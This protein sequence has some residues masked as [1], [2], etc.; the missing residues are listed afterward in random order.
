MSRLISVEARSV[1]ELFTGEQGFRL[2]WFQ[3]AYAWRT[4]QV[5]R[6]IGDLVE[7][8]E[9]KDDA[10]FLLGTL[11][12]AEAA[13]RDRLAIVDGHQRIMTL[14]IIAAVLRDL[15]APG[16]VRSRLDALVG[17]GHGGYRFEPQSYI[18]EFLERYVQ[19]DGGTAL[20]VDE[21]EA[22][23]SD[24]ERCV[25]EV[26]E[27][28]LSRLQAGNS[29][30]ILRADIALLLL[31][32][33][34]VIV[35]IY[36]SEDYAWRMLDVEE[37]TRLTF[38]PGAQ[39]KATILGVMPAKERDF[40]S[41]TWEQCEERI[42]TAGV[43]E[44]LG[45][46][47]VLKA[48]KR[49]ERPVELDIC[50]LFDVNRGGGAFL[51]QWLVPN[52]DRYER[53]RGN[54]RAA[55]WNGGGIAPAIEAL[56]WIEPAVWMPAAMHWLDKHGPE[57]EGGVEFFRRLERLT[58]LMRIAGV[59]PSHQTRR[60][61]SVLDQLD[62]GSRAAADIPAL[63]IEPSLRRDALENLRSQNFCLKH[64]AHLVLRRLSVLMGRDTG[65]VDREHVTIE[66]MLPRNPDKN[67][68]WWRAFAATS[69]VKAHVNRIGNLTFLSHDDNQAAAT[70][71]WPEKRKILARSGFVLSENAAEFAEWDRAAI[72]AR[73][74]AL[75]ALLMRD[76][77]L[78]DE[79]R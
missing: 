76:W 1:G 18:A 10:E 12:L 34:R 42:G 63:A 6:L 74:E 78:L 44:V 71:D 51:D 20:E 64:H 25:V 31:D 55:A 62:D 32:R 75:I 9:R 37:T 79:T 41:R 38:S 4:Q 70:K 7:A 47:R 72:V 45:Y 53:L 56:N 29:A 26:R 65:P 16:T 33:C 59:D 13:E 54:G 19:R 52:V 28:I 8:L 68:R 48:R 77:G 73:G 49:S 23:F 2:P 36:D 69:D 30:G 40:A 17:R 66:H 24:S 50:K 35:Q 11:L 3:R 39:A 27:Y 67:R 61:I 60:I 5:A 22:S 58:W 46:I 15:A 43:G 21:S 57:G 14:T